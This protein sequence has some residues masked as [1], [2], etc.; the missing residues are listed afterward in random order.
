MS[1]STHPPYYILIS[2]SS[3]SSPNQGPL[4]NSLGHPN[5]QYHYSDDSPLSLLPQHP[6]EC[7]VVLDHDP[8]SSAPP[9]VRSISETVVVTGLKVEEAPGAAAAVEDD[10]GKNDRMFIIETTNDVRALSASQEDRKSARATLALFKRRN[11]T[12][13]RALLHSN[14]NQ[15]YL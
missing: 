10:A 3:L 14:E 1:T 9:T 11:E 7:V 8:Q 4:S 12:L 13:R 2:H 15:T 5:I 6:E